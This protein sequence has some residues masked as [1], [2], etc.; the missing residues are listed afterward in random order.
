ML[1]PFEELSNDARIWIFQSNR[2]MSDAE[3]LQL[4]NSTQQFVNEWT[5]HN[6][7]LKA[8]CVIMHNYF[9]II[10]VDENF[11]QASGCS[12]DKAFRHVTQMGDAMKINF[13][14]RLKVAAMHNNEIQLFP[15]FDIKSKPDE[16][17]DY[18]FFK[19][20]IENKLQLN[21]GW[22]VNAVEI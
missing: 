15:Y 17:A 7:T 2:L 5:A 14:D 3:Q 11:N 18:K 6:Q 1:V 10:A 21:S 9:L 8:S 19:N 4:I 12:I 22:M 16:F 13:F 20:A